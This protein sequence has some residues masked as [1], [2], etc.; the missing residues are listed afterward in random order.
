MNTGSQGLPYGYAMLVLS[1]AAAGA[2][3]V[4]LAVSSARRRGSRGALEFSLLMAA[5]SIWCFGYFFEL[6]GASDS[7]KI[8]W[9][10]IEY[11]AIESIPVLW[12]LMAAR[13]TGRMDLSRPARIAGLALIP[14]ASLIMVFTNDSHH[15]MWK[16]ILPDSVSG[17]LILRF[18]HGPWFWVSM[19]YAYILLAVATVLFFSSLIT[20]PPGY[21]SQAAAVV[22]GVTIPWIG[23]TLYLAGAYSLPVDLTPFCFT[24]SG[25]AF[26]WALFC[27]RFLEIVPFA[28]D[29]VIE[30]MQEPVVILDESDRIVDVNPSARALMAAGNRDLIGANA[31]R[32]FPAWRASIENA[33]GDRDVVE[34]FSLPVDSGIRFFQADI[35]VL[36]DRRG[37]R[38][39]KV[40][41]LHDSTRRRAV[42]ENLRRSEEKYKGLV[43]SLGDVFFCLDP[44]GNVTYISPMIGRITKHKPEDLVGANY[45]HFI[46]PDDIDVVSGGIRLSYRGIR[47]PAEFRLLDASG[48]VRHVRAYA[49]PLMEKRK[50]IGLTGI[51]TDVTQQKHLVEQLHQAQKMEA[52][53]RL[54]GGIAHD[55]N[56]L[57]TAIN[58]F[59]EML[60][61]GQ[62]IDGESREWVG[63]IR[64]SIDRGADLVRQLL[65]FSRKQKM[66][67]RALNVNDLIRGLEKILA[68]L[69]E[70]GITLVTRLAKDPGKVFADPGQIELALM[71]LAV[72]AR[73]AM[74]QGGT[75][76]I[77]TSRSHPPSGR[78]KSEVVLRISDTGYGMDEHVKSHLFEPFFT[79]KEPGK[80][81]GLGLSTV[82]GIVKQSGG[83]IKV[84]SERG[85]GTTVE[86]RFPCRERHSLAHRDG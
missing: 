79:T 80:G 11:I 57:L 43:E 39:G 58:G 86:L 77:E 28:R 2:L 20:A 70:Q 67:P 8:S 78:G 25:C 35:S 4:A 61:V 17:F 51:L 32:I 16:E 66:Q 13:Y 54:T 48:A 10:R 9:A 73:D 65:A 24:A 52:V 26:A 5:V 59:T 46:H 69:L 42:E 22:I 72:N 7:W 23:N 55:F 41:V 63:E 85:V 33:R 38:S 1:L 50:V 40:I 19:S 18:S 47:G 14:L 76:T 31:G 75:L 62:G 53:G 74:P 12:L 71:N 30:H 83:R 21:R 82:Y 29:A 84:S 49:Y 56:N 60:L 64:K 27:R 36:R 68:R 81:T 44:R 34:G 15:L 45:T 3:S 37:R 6:S